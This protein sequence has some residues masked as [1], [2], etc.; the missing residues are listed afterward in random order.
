MGRLLTVQP[1]IDARLKRMVPMRAELERLGIVPGLG[2]LLVGSDMMA[3]GYAKWAQRTLEMLEIRCLRFDLEA[4]AD[5]ETLIEVLDMLGK[6]ADIHGI[7]PIWPMPAQSLE[8]LVRD[9]VD[10]RKD[11]DGLGYHSLGKLMLG[12]P[13]FV[14]CAVDGLFALIDHYGIAL[15]GRRV[16]LIGNGRMIGRALG[17][18]LSRRGATVTHCHS[19]TAGLADI[20]RK[21]DVLISAM[22]CPGMVDDT[23]VHAD[24]I[25]F[26]LGTAM[27]DG[28]Q[29]GDLKLN[30][31]ASAVSAYTKSPGG[32]SR[33]TDYMLAEHVLRAALQGVWDA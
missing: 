14:N 29:I 6:R 24:Q 15:E 23:F 17:V 4:E 5:E 7:L 27:V 31:P 11:V 16:C 21:S 32:L 26:D 25:V 28:R 8:Q 3:K 22:G 19:R 10:R 9:R 13:T 1:V 18:M 12:E 33:L 20:A 2:M 30:A